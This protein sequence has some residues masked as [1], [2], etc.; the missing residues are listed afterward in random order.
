MLSLKTGLLAV[1]F[2]AVVSSFSQVFN[3]GIHQAEFKNMLKNGIVYVKTDDAKFDSCMIS[4]L[5][6][7][8]TVSEFDTIAKWGHPD[9]T[10]TILFITTKKPAREFFEDRRNQKVLVLYPGS[11]YELK[12]EPKMERTLGYIYFNGF[13][14]LMEQKQEYLFAKMMLGSLDAGIKWINEHR[15]EDV[16]LILNQSIGETIIAESGTP[17]GNTLIIHREQTTNY[18]DMKLVEKAKI[19]H[20]LVGQDE[21]YK[22]IGSGNENYYALYFAVN[23]FTELSIVNIKT[24]KII[25]TRHFHEDYP[26]LTSKEVKAIARYFK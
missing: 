18:L 19:R 26:K 20:R 5:E 22:L 1:H 10:K 21:Y 7:I 6:T 23:D 4:A 2:L 16:G 12:G 24:G 17:V 11:M 13:F 8:W 25:F 3:Q 14:D 15:L 9:K